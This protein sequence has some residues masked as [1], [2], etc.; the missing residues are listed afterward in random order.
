MLSQ[1]IDRLQDAAAAFWRFLTVPAR[2]EGP[3]M[4]TWPRLDALDGG[5]GA[6]DE[7]HD[8]PACPDYGPPTTRLDA[9]AACRA[10]D[11]FEDWRHLGPDVR[12]QFRDAVRDWLP[13]IDALDPL[14]HPLPGKGL[15]RRLGNATTDQPE[16]PGKLPET[17]SAIAPEPLPSAR[18][19]RQDDANRLVALMHSHG[20]ANADDWP[21]LTADAPKPSP[22]PTP[23]DERQTGP[24]APQTETAHH[25]GA[26]CPA[27]DVW[28]R[29]EA[30]PRCGKRPIDPFPVTVNPHA[31]PES[32]PSD[33]MRARHAIAALADRWHERQAIA[34]N[35]LIA[36]LQHIAAALPRDADAAPAPRRDVRGRFT[37]PD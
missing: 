20:T 29:Q 7:P 15:G 3:G 34:G 25:P 9:L 16:S 19:W 10:A 5:A 21:N 33:A 28:H 22:A 17:A 14:R 12:E 31:M 36:A 2:L 11:Y 26:Y 1:T 24:D 4:A 8:R 37:R 18:Q 32:R 27:C 35:D 30:C 6:Q 23:A 13:Q